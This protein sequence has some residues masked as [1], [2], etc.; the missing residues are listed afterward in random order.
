MQFFLQNAVF[1][2]AVF[3]VSVAVRVVSETWL[4][5]QFLTA[6]TNH[7]VLTGQ[8]VSDAVTIKSLLWFK[9]SGIQSASLAMNR[10][11]RFINYT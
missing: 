7:R 4:M 11:N 9:L 8:F 2:S 3:N 5:L 10:N 1:H 6:K